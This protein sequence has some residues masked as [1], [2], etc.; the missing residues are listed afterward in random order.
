MDLEDEYIVSSLPEL[1]HHST[2]PQKNNLTYTLHPSFNVRAQL[3]TTTPPFSPSCECMHQG[4]T[5]N[6]GH[7]ECNFSDSSPRTPDSHAPYTPSVYHRSQLASL[8]N[9]DSS[10]S[11]FFTIT[12]GPSGSDPDNTRYTERR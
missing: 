8:A 7:A 11:S 5:I 6:R 12:P 9:L 10:H 4:T 1:T 2:T 3:P